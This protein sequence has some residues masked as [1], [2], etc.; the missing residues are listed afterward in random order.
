ML[1]FVSY[2]SPLIFVDCS[3]LI[4]SVIMIAENKINVHKNLRLEM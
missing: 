1:F 4:Y 3:A 2:I